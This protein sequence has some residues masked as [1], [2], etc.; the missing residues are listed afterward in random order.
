MAKRAAALALIASILPLAACQ[1]GKPAERAPPTVMVSTPLQKR[2]VDWDD[3]VGRFVSIDAV[4]VRPRVSGYLQRIAFRDGQ[5]VNKGD[6][7]FTIDPRPYAA[8]LAQARAQ[9]ARARATLATADVELKRARALFEAKA[10]S[11]QELTAREVAALQAR[12]DVAATEAAERA[13]AL[14]VEFTQVRAPLSGRVS[15]RRVAVGNLVTAD[16]TVLTTLV[17][18]DPI[19]FAFE[20]SEALFL[21]RERGFGRA[22]AL[23]DVVHVR[24]QDE[25][26]YRWTGKLEFLDNALDSASGVI[27]G[28]AVL[29]NPGG[30]L[31]PGMFGHM[32]LA[33]SAP[34]DGLLVPDNAVTT[35]QSRQIVYVVGKDDVV[36]LR[37]VE[38]GPLIDGLR[39]VRSG[40]KADDRV[41][42]AGTE[43][44]RPG[45]KVT[46]KPG[47]IAPQAPVDGPAYR[48]PAASAGSFVS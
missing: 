22:H 18:H 38:T 7:L 42:I 34:Y 30:L 26:A 46:P 37:P 45:S 5:Q 19:R 14:N 40:L 24:L 25:P 8:A 29:P 36:R 32:R 4:E 47:R 16:Q 13:A 20:A 6:L 11:Q 39:V 33:G 35:D 12:A 21:K 17:N 9:T 15:D 48:A 41:V 2:V 44:A 1:E 28:R 10:G 23:G 3:Y 43:R 27:R 31:T